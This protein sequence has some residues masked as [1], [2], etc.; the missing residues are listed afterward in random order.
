MVMKAILDNLDGVSDAFKGEYTE[1][2]GKFYLAV[3]PVEGYALENVEG[4]KTALSAANGK[5]TGA[6]KELKKFGSAWDKDKGWQHSVDPTKVKTAVAKYDEFS[7]FDP[8]KEAD[9]VAQAK[10]DAMKQQLVDQH[11][12]ELGSA[13]ERNALLTSTVNDLLIKQE[14]ATALAG[15]KGDAVLLMPHI[16]RQT[17]V[18]EKDGKFFVEVLDANGNVRIGDGKG[19]NMTIVQL[20][21]EMKKSSTFGK[22]FE[23]DG[24]SGS[25]KQQQGN[26]GGSSSGLKRS[27]MSPQQKAE[28][29]EKN[30]AQAF[31]KLPK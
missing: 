26:G 25:G 7:S 15:A 28:Y 19:T 14:A 16:E 17:R 22:A 5:F 24:T 2:D 4:L 30:G 9:K 23:G 18:G 31:L 20:V 1:K 3:E 8:E 13:T 27:E 6:E 29:Q 11:Q 21:E 12:A 10:I